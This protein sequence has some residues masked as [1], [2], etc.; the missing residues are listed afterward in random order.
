MST[1]AEIWPRAL[2]VGMLATAAT[3]SLVAWRSAHDYDAARLIELLPR[4][5]SVLAYVDLDA[6]RSAGLLESLAGP[7]SAQDPEYQKFVRD[8]GFDYRHDLNAAAVSFADGNTYMAVRG[9]FQWKRLADYATTQGGSC[10]DTVCQMPANQAGKFISFYPLRS[11]VLVLAVSRQED[12]ITRIGKQRGLA[13]LQPAGPITISAEGSYF[14]RVSGLPPGAQAFLSPLAKAARVSFSATAA[15]REKLEL[16]VDADCAS[17]EIAK[18][19]AKQL[20]STT[21]LLRNMLAR[22]KMTPSPADL[23]GVL[24]AGT[25]EAKEKRAL[26]TWPLD[27]RFVEGLFGAAD[28]SD[29]K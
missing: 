29:A 21:D 18:D 12:G 10:R 20:T 2:I 9:S 23:S 3:V 14:D 13:P 11:N 26:G 22:E 17:P 27:R 1:H 6:L 8:T 4:E 24:V 5:K 25:F 7:T 28:D 19:I 15:T 16:R